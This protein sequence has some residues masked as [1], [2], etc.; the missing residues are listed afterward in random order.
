MDHQEQ[1]YRHMI[2]NLAIDLHSLAMAA[3]RVYQ[4]WEQGESLDEPMDA[5]RE[6]LAD[7]DLS[8]DEEDF[9]ENEG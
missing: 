5:L 1:I 9:G 2:Q 8:D 7:I 6:V 3:N 4:A